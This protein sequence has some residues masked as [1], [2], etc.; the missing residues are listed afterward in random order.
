MGH[1]GPRRTLL[2]KGIGGGSLGLGEAYMDGDWHADSIDQLFDRVISAKLSDKLGMTVPI[3]VLMLAAHLRN[4]QSLSRE[5]EHGDRSEEHTSEL[6]S[7][8]NLVC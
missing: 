2:P 5:H 6:Q 3:A 1:S 8:V 7:H 4:R